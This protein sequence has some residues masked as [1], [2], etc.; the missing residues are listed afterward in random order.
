[1]EIIIGCIPEFRIST[2]VTLAI[3]AILNIGILHIRGTG[4]LNG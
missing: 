2:D 4:N 1:M 3:K